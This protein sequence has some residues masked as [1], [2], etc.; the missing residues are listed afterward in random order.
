MRQRCSNKIVSSFKHISAQLNYRPTHLLGAE[1]CRPRSPA[2][3]QSSSSSH[4]SCYISR[5]QLGESVLRVALLLMHCAQNG[6]LCPPKTWSLLAILVSGCARPTENV[7]TTY[8]NRRINC[9]LAATTGLYVAALNLLNGDNHV[10]WRSD[11]GTTATT[12]AMKIE[13]RKNGRF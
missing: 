4:T 5:C 3:W 11:G 8:Q 13:P 12:T 7:G 2:K 1:Y 9:V 10:K 6:T